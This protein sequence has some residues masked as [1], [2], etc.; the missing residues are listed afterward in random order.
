M[1]KINKKKLLGGVFSIKAI[2]NSVSPQWRNTPPLWIDIFVPSS[3]KH[4]VI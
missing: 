1:D 4:C 3:Y 2:R